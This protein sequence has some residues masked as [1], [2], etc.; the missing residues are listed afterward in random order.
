M[1]SVRDLSD[2][3]SYFMTANHETTVVCVTSTFTKLAGRLAST[4]VVLHTS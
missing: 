4:K 1:S 2:T 3:H